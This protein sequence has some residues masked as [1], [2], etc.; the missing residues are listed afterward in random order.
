MP[1]KTFKELVHQQQSDTS[2][3][4]VIFIMHFATIS[5][6]YTIHRIGKTAEDQHNLKQIIYKNIL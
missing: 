3:K 1:F 4:S 6:V 5:F 2:K